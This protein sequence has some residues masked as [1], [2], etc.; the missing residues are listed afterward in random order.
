MEMI[1]VIIALLSVVIFGGILI[2]QTEIE[3]I[4]R[5]INGIKAKHEVVYSTYGVDFGSRESITIYATNIPLD[6]KYKDWLNSE[7]TW[8]DN[9]VTGMDFISQEE[10][11]ILHGGESIVPNYEKKIVF[12]INHGGASWPSELDGSK[13]YYLCH[14]ATTGGRTI[15]ENKKR[16]EYLYQRIKAQNPNVKLIRPLILIPDGTG[17]ADAMKRCYSLIDASHAIIL[18]MGWQRSKGCEMEH[19]YAARTEKGILF[20]CTN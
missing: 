20:I 11:Y 12:D 15:E 13:I 6:E 16:E 2:T 4:K 18:P 17:H 14:P 3:D 8:P 7:I 1:K 10:E 5:T 19:R 9:R